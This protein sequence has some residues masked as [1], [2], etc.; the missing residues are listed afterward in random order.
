MEIVKARTQGFCFG[1][2]LTYKHAHAETTER[3]DVYPM[4]NIVHNPLNVK[5]LDDKGL[6]NVES[7]D[8]I[9]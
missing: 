4:G 8:D 9:D 2:E 7:L 1:V 6:K 5:E 3:D